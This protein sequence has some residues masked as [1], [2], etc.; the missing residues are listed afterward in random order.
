MFGDR[1]ACAQHGSLS[2]IEAAS[3]KSTQIAYLDSPRNLPS[4]AAAA[5]QLASTTVS[6]KRT[7]VRFTV[8]VSSNSWTDF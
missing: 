3:C 4:L 8:F 1:R 2:Q 6:K 5:A 7:T